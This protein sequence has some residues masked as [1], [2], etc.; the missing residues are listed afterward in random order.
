[1]KL[2]RLPALEGETVDALVW[3]TLGARDGLVEAVHAANPGLAALGP[4]L[5]LGT[6][7][8]VPLPPSPATAKPL[9]QLWS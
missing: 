9:V 7:I 3:R 5:P 6:E 4:F 1:M 8:A 2:V